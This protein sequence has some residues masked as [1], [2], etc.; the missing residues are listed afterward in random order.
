LKKVGN[1]P[2]MEEALEAG[3]PEP[4]KKVEVERV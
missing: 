4:V 1:L 3:N 2:T